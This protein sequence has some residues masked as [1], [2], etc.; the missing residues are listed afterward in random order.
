MRFFF[1]VIQIFAI[2]TISVGVASADIGKQSAKENL[3][4]SE[5]FEKGVCRYIYHPY[6]D[7]RNNGALLFS[8]I[9]KFYIWAA[10]PYTFG[11]THGKYLQWDTLETLAECFLTKERHRPN[12]TILPRKQ[13][14]WP[15]NAPEKN[16]ILIFIKVGEV[17]GEDH[18]ENLFHEKLITFSVN[19]YRSDLR[20]MNDVTE[21]NSFSC[22]RAFPLVADKERLLRLLT[23]ATTSCLNREYR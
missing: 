16:A 4:F 3:T 18:F 15:K 11:E 13:E 8:G 22:A 14:D 7:G 1:S 17:D 19:F 9:D 6:I 10:D 20:S 5:Q 12:V 23:I 2:L 21:A